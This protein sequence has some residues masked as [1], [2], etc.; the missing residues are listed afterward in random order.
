MKEFVVYT[1]LRI[2]LF[3]GALAIVV[4]IWSLVGD[5]V[6]MLWAVVVAFLISGVAS[7]VLLN[8]QREQFAARVEERASRIS[9]KMEAHKAKEDTD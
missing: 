2:G 8:R 6:P 7:L 1:L 9:E 5:E 3:A 4:G